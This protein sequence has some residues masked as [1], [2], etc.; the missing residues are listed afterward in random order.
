MLPAML[1]YPLEWRQVSQLPPPTLHH[2]LIEKAYICNL[3]EIVLYQLFV[4]WNSNQILIMMLLHINDKYHILH[5]IVLHSHFV[6]SKVRT[7]FSRGLFSVR[8]TQ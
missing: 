7:R 8:T 3:F 4:R 5:D 2:S 1:L 6:L